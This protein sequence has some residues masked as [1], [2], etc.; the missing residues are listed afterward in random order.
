MDFH[1]HRL[2]LLLCNLYPLPRYLCSPLDSVNF[3]HLFR[4][5][6]RLLLFFAQSV[7][8]ERNRIFLL[9]HKLIFVLFDI[10]VGFSLSITFRL[11][12]TFFSSTFLFRF[13]CF[14]LHFCS[15]CSVYCLLSSLHATAVSSSCNSEVY[16]ERIS[17]DILDQI[18]LHLS[19]LFSGSFFADFF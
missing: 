10:Y 3:M 18:S 17:F 8:N 5:F 13:V 15:F 16:T 4:L 9:N 2:T 1:F 14:I 12:C 11:F 19:R 7:G 6:S